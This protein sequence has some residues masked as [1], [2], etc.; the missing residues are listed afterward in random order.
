MITKMVFWKIGE[1]IDYASCCNVYSYHEMFH[2]QIQNHK[3]DKRNAQDE[4]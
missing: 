1:H 4:L 2:E 3:G